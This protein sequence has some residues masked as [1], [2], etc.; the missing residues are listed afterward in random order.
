MNFEKKASF[1]SIEI[2]KKKKKSSAKKRKKI[3]LFNIFNIPCK[4]KN[5][6]RYN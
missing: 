2:K 1:L 5:Y 4:E 6:G 3:E